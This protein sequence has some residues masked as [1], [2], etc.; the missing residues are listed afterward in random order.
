MFD[1]NL[2]CTEIIILVILVVV[3]YFK[4]YSNNNENFD[5][6]LTFIQDLELKKI[7]RY[8]HIILFKNQIEYSI[9]GDT[10]MGAV[11]YNDRMPTSSDASI[12]V[13]ITDKKK[14]KNIDW[15]QYNCNLIETSD[16][17]KISFNDVQNINFPYVNLIFATLNGEKYVYTRKGND[18]YLST[19]ELYP[20]TLYQIDS[21]LLYG[22]NKA[23]NYLDRYTLS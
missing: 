23:V 12:L 16:G 14:I 13:K 3:L 21:L 8:I 5:P 11:K 10:L 2:D 19:D 7:L 9:C 4:Y 6:Q 15:K 18:E 1:I 20:L 22:P 17:Y